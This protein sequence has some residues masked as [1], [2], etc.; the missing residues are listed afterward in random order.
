VVLDARDPNPKKKKQQ[1]KNKKKIYKY[2]ESK[3]RRAILAS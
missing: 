3:Q 2:A 1:Q